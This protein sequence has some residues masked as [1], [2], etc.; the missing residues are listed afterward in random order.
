MQHSF[1]TKLCAENSPQTPRVIFLGDCA[2]RAQ[3]KAHILASQNLISLRSVEQ[4]LQ[5]CG[6]DRIIN[7]FCPKQSL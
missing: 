7:A 2:E 4:P 1:P 3:G 5:C 6:I